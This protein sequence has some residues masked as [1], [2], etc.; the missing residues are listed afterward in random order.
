MT[1][2]IAE[3]VGE[4]LSSVEF[5]EDY[6]QWHFEGPTLTAFVPPTLRLHGRT[7][8]F[9]EQGYR[10]ELSARINHNV[11]AAYVRDGDAVIIEFDDEAA[12]CISLK[13]EDQVGPEAGHFTVSA[14]PHS[15]L[16][17]F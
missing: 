8:R 12:I 6:V 17:D 10:D 4:Q 11:L 5:V 1:I 2:P 3:I 7:I 14:D 16:L 13:P 9:G 15:A